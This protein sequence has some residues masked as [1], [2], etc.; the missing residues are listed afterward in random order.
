MIEC[1]YDIKGKIN[2]FLEDV[3]PESNILSAL[4]TVN[5]NY[6]DKEPIVMFTPGACG[7]YVVA[8]KT[9]MNYLVASH[10]KL[11]GLEME[12]YGLYLAAHM[13]GRKALLIKSVSDF[14]DSKK[15]D[16]YHKMCSYISAWFLFEFLKYTY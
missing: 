2:T 3:H 15:G 10:R 6:I 7:S 4:K 8:D 14:A 12:G 16:D 1:N 9:F 5:L 11:K 13:L